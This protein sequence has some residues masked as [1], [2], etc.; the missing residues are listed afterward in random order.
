MGLVEKIA[1]EVHNGRETKKTEKR[2]SREEIHSN[3]KFSQAI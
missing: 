1:N 3:I 2:V